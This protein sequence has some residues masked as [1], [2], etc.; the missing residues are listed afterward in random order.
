MVLV[1]CLSLAGEGSMTAAAVKRSHVGR[2]SIAA[3]RAHT[4]MALP[5]G[6]VTAWGA[7]TRGQLGDGALVNRSTP[8]AVAGLDNVV[9]V[10]AGAAHIFAVPTTGE[11][12]AWGANTLGRIG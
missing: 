2:G 5:D 8:V 9:A 1:V 11:V 6:H 3:G 10:A 7:G 12:W 4:V